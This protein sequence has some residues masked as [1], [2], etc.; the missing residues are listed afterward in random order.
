ML[1]IIRLAEFFFG[2][3]IAIT[4]SFDVNTQTCAVLIIFVTSSMSTLDGFLFP[5]FAP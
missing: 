4:W 5:N 1:F 2:M 3:M